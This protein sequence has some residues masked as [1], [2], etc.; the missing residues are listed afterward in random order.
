[1]ILFIK[2]LV[3]TFVV[4]GSVAVILPLLITGETILRFSFFGTIFFT[5]GFAIYCL[6]VWDF[7]TLGNG[8]PSPIDAP[9][10]LVIKGLYHY[11]RNPMYV[12]V[13]LVIIGWTFFFMSLSM[14]I[15]AVF[16]VLCFQILIVYYE[17]PMLQQV[18]ND[19]YINYKKTVNRWL[20][21]GRA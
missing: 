6:C 17:E 19:D 13:L 14:L 9:K 18:F 10:N 20:P 21:I 16:I 2:S 11:T 3:F 5:S 1:M 7:I 12:G 8:T 4:P 15:Y